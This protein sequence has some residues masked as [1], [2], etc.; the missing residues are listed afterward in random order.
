MTEQLSL[1][2]SSLTGIHSSSST[3]FFNHGIY[4]QGL[5]N[6][7]QTENVV[8]LYQYLGKTPTLYHVGLIISGKMEAKG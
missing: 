8:L 1:S 4:P 3:V 6:S 5:L 7:S 2:L